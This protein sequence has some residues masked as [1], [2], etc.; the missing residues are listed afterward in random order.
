MKF[1]IGFH[2]D[3]GSANTEAAQTESLTQKAEIRKSLVEV[4]F[5]VRNR[6]YSYYNDRFDLHEGDNVCVEGK[7]EGIQGVVTDVNYNFKIK[8]SDYK[9]VISV[10][11]TSVSGDLYI[12]EDMIVAFD[13]E[14]MP[15][16][17][18]SSWFRPMFCEEEE[19]ISGSDDTSFPLDEVQSWPIRPDIMERGFEYAKSGNVKYICVDGEHGRAI[20]AGSEIYDIEFRL[21][22]GLISELTCNCYCNSL[23]KH[24]AATLIV[25][26]SLMDNILKSYIDLYEESDYFA[27]VNKGTF[28]GFVMKD[29]KTGRLRLD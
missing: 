15:Y 16:E 9:R 21:N 22:E 5:P 17:K 26:R 14:A 11:D 4:Y 7:L 8:L 13:R 2:A 23:C 20:V 29:R 1:K 27:A 12:A 28:Y 18:I 6:A 25:L 3:N 24:D 19:V 10:I